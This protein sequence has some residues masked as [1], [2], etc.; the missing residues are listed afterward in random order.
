MRALFALSFASGAVAFAFACSSSETEKTPAP[1]EDAAADAPLEP[2]EPVEAAPPTCKLPSGVSTGRK[3]CDDCLL[4]S[5]CTVINTCFDDKL[6]DALNK[7]INDCGST[8]G[9]SD[10]G[11]QCVRDCNKGREAASTKEL[12]LLTCENERCGTDCK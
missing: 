9:R 12:D 10:A 1:T 6:C 4:K 3:V 5:C 8:F 7:C 2:V 11:A